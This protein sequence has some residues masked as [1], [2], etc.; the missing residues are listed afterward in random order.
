ML[1]ALFV[2]GTEPALA[3]WRMSC[4]GVA[5]IARIDPIVSPGEISSHVHTIK[6]A[7]GM[8]ICL[9]SSLDVAN[10]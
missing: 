3:Y 7:S 5:G 10:H 1:L 9:C 2:L 6:G 4:M 8:Q